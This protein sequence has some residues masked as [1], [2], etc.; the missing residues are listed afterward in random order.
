L[1]STAAPF[2]ALE[3]RFSSV[4]M[5]DDYVARLPFAA[6]AVVLIGARDDCAD[7]TTGIGKKLNGQGLNGG[8]AHGAPKRML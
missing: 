3:Q 4:L 2:G 8:R 6:Q 5:A 1:P 7:A